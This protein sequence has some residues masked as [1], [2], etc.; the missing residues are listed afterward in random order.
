MTVTAN[1]YPVTMRLHCPAC[2]RVV[3]TYPGIYWS[4]PDGNGHRHRYAYLRRHNAGPPTLPT[5]R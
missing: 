4:V 2:G 5:R 3:G 1:P